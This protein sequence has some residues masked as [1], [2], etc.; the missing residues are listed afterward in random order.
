[1][2]KFGFLILTAASLYLAAAPVY[3]LE[4]TS[5]SILLAQN[6][7]EDTAQVVP[8][9][10]TAQ[11]E[12]TLI[13]ARK[14]GIPSKTGV[15][16]S[17]AMY[18]S[19]ALAGWGQIENGKDKK[20][21]LFIAAELFCL[22]GVVYEQVRLGR[23]GQSTYEKDLI[24]TD[25]N[26]FVIYWLGAKLFGMVDAYVDAQLRDFDVESITPKGKRGAEPPSSKP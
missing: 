13:P 11:G 8:P 6:A 21:L 25:R 17:T 18:H 23:S 2:L 19:L 15:L 16:P 10:T 1:V 14:A 24:R 22:G 12:L 26:T 7:A 3:S 4:Q 20:A 9:D 5:R